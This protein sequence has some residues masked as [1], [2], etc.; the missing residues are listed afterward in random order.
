MEV[1]LDANTKTYSSL[2]GDKVSLEGLAQCF[3]TNS[4]YMD[5]PI[6]QYAETVSD[7]FM[8]VVVHNPSTVDMKEAR[9]AVPHGHFDVYKDDVE[10]DA[11]VV[12]HKDYLE[13]DDIDSC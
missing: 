3:A 5:C 9:I 1:A 6:S 2:M 13:G 7:Y 10:A 12:C 11:Y 8:N 4:T